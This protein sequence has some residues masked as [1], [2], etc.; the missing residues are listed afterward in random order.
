M[1]RWHADI[2]GF[3]VRSAARAQIA[4]HPPSHRVG[5]RL[6]LVASSTL[7][8]SLG[9]AWGQPPSV[10]VTA[11]VA[12]HDV[13]PPTGLT[14]IPASSVLAHA[15]APMLAFDWQ[16]D[17]DP[18]YYLVS[19]KL[20][21]VRALWDG[22]VLRFRS[23]RPIAA[24]QWFTAAL[25][26]TPLD[27]EL[28]I[29]RGQFDRVS[30][31]ARRGQPLDTEWQALR[32]WVFDLPTDPRPFAD[33]AAALT[34]LVQ[35]TGVAWLHVV[36]QRRVADAAHLQRELVA[37]VAQGGEGLMLHQQD[38]L[39]RPGRSESLRKFKAAKDEEA[40]VVAHL[41]GKGKFAGRLGALVLQRSN[42]QRF[43]LGTGF[44]DAQRENP[45]AIGSIVTYRFRDRTPNGVPR[46]ASFVRV[47]LPE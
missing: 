11:P 35:R 25:P 38:A 43:S 20:D 42:G 28:W 27:G 26:P 16:A 1:P 36:A 24:P 14:A 13:S 6:A 34:E 9:L 19:E 39:R 45:P 32:Y 40:Q 29:A 47:Q 44:S 4:M 22:K 8:A 10:L 5:A 15:V 18:S 37:V 3:S 31:T 7:A 12:S 33:R 21:G 23:G 30:A 2:S 46:F 41:P 17:M